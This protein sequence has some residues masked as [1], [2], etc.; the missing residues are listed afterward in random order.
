MKFRHF[1][2]IKTPKKSYLLKKWHVTV[3]NEVYFH[4]ILVLY[5]VKKVLSKKLSFNFLKK[6]LYKSEI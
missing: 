6:R 2:S 3:G 4:Y 1:L 5:V